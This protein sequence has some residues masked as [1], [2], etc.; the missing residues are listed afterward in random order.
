M[1]RSRWALS[2]LAIATAPAVQAQDAPAAVKPDLHLSRVGGGDRR[3][4]GAPVAAP[5]RDR[6][7]STTKEQEGQYAAFLTKEIAAWRQS[8]S[9]DTVQAS[10]AVSQRETAT[11]KGIQAAPPKI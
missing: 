4:A 5:D 7:P 9:L 10:L 8:I 6:F 1:G 2:A 11:T 3:A